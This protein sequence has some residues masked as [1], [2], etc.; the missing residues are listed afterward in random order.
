MISFAPDRFERLGAFAILDDMK[1]VLL[2]IGAFILL[3]LV[4]A[5]A[6]GNLVS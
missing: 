5:Y 6:T 4:N 1:I 3:L 2:V